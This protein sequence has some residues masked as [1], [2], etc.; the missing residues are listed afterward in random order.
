MPFYNLHKKNNRGNIRINVTPSCVRVTTVVVKKKQYVLNIM[1]V[2]VCSLVI[3][4]Y[5][6]IC[7]PSGFTI[8]FS[9]YLTNGTIFEKKKKINEYN[10]RVLIFPATF[11]CNISHKKK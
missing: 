8:F 2:R 4:H 1:Y 9:H 6:V 5:T 11:V 3:Q 7:G 10:T